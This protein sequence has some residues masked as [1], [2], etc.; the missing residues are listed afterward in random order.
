MAKAGDNETA[1]A[2]EVMIK[3]KIVQRFSRLV[4]K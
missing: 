2:M 1:N 4:I 3:E